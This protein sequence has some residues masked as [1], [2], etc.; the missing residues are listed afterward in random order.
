MY[1]VLLS[2]NRQVSQALELLRGC[3]DEKLCA[4]LMEHL[5]K[6]CQARELSLN[7]FS[8]F[9]F[10]SSLAPFG[11]EVIESMELTLSQLGCL[12]KKRKKKTF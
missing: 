9:P 4:R 11:R 5:L 10:F 2:L 3:S 7:W 6:E 1:S 12:L 8:S